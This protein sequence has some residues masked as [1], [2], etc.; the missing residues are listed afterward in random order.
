MKRVTLSRLVAGTIVI[1]SVVTATTVAVAQQAPSS[2][3][4]ASGRVS[5]AGTSNIH[6]YTASTTSLRVRGA[7]LAI[8]TANP[9]FV[10]E[11]AKPGVLQDFEIAVSAATLVS[12]KDG[13]DKN[14]HKALKVQ[15]HPDITFRLNRLDAAGAPGALRAAG[16]LTVAGVERAVAFDLTVQL[17]GSTLSVKGGVPLVMT[18]YGITPPKAMLGM[19]KTDP[20]VTVTF[21]ASFIVPAPTDGATN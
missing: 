18:D 8:D 3:G 21:E 17:S 11:L 4:V 16:V 5:I 2:L 6:P 19:L 1:A 10:A 15:Q 7:M 9:A 13:L 14:M 20:K 12:G